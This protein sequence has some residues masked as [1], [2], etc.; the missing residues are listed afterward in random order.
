MQEGK[1]DSH[2]EGR[3]DMGRVAGHSNKLLV[4]RL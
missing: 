1:E 3:E 4:Y 2:L